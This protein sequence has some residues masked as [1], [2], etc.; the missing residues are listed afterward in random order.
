[1]EITK[2]LVLCSFSYIREITIFVQKY[3]YLFDVYG[4]INTLN[5]INTFVYL[6]IDFNILKAQ[7]Y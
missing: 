1:M 3:E 5:V 6:I 2:I 7:V 4:E